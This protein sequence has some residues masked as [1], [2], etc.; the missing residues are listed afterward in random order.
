M[1]L[2]IGWKTSWIIRDSVTSTRSVSRCKSENERRCYL[3]FLK[4]VLYHNFRCIIIKTHKISKLKLNCLLNL[5]IWYLLALTIFPIKFYFNSE[6]VHQIF[7]YKWP[8]MTLWTVKDVSVL[9]LW[10]YISVVGQA[11]NLKFSIYVHLPYI[12]K[13]FGWCCAM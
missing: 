5:E 3:D 8:W 1:S 12:N 6:L 13:M 2:L 4:V 9:I 10:N 11:R 7:F